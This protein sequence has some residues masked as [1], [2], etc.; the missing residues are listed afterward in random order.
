MLTADPEFD[1]ADVFA[2]QYSSPHLGSSLTIG[3]LG[4]NLRLR[5]SDAG[6]LNY[7][8]I[9]FLAHSMG[10]LVVRSFLNA[11]SNSPYIKNVAMLY[12]FATPTEGSELAKLFSLV[13]NNPQYG[14]MAPI[15]RGNHLG[16]EMRQYLDKEFTIPAFGAYETAPIAGMI[17]VPFQRALAL[18][19]KPPIAVPEATHVT[20]VQ[21]ENL[22]STSYVA[23][24]DAYRSTIKPPTSFK[25]I[26][27]SGTVR[28]EI[29]KAVNPP[30]KFLMQLGSEFRD[31]QGNSLTQFQDSGEKT[32]SMR[33][34]LTEVHPT[35]GMAG[36]D[37]LP[38][39]GRIVYEFSFNKHYLPRGGRT[40][41][42][43]DFREIS[44]YRIV[45]QATSLPEQP[46]AIPPLLYPR[47]DGQFS[48][49]GVFDNGNTKVLLETQIRDDVWENIS[50]KA[51]DVRA[52]YFGF[53]RVFRQ[54]LSH[55]SFLEII[56]E[57]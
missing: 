48:V 23:F 44:D 28:F 47:Q 12:F 24:R 14:D 42:L 51:T 2:Y 43:T 8:R 56:N 11:F 36:M 1:G 31:E 13:S 17:I 9:V 49:V 34:L 55:Q 4:E 41:S 25:Q 33:Y 26:D 35:R 57:R 7:D 32:D 45:V 20:I 5:L 19:N 38:E 16:E 50:L 21:P 53:Q 30:E 37:R 52:L 22:E 3:E 46:F 15:E 18:T 29:E 39:P 40:F 54:W 10:G 6:V 27:V